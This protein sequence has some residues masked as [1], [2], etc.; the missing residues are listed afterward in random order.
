M[1]FFKPEDFERNSIV[2]AGFPAGAIHAAEV[3]NSKLQREG[4]IVYGETQN[5]P[6]HNVSFIGM[7]YIATL[8]SIEPIEQ[9]KHPQEKVERFG[10]VIGT[11]ENQF[12]F[13]CECGAKVQ[14]LGFEEMK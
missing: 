10:Q 1:N 7:K 8:I 3:A 4:R 9:C 5:L 13:M 11:R 14:P 2:H 6:W 12:I